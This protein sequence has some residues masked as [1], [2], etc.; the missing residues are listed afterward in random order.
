MPQT[1]EL[2]L[3]GSATVLQSLHLASWSR[4]STF[5]LLLCRARHSLMKHVDRNSKDWRDRLG[6]VL[7]TLLSW[8]GSN[9]GRNISLCAHRLDDSSIPSPG[10]LP[11]LVF[12]VII[13]SL[14]IASSATRSAQPLNRVTAMRQFCR[15]QR[16]WTVRSE[17]A[18]CRPGTG[19]CQRSLAG[20]PRA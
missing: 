8:W 7:A 13:S 2:F 18:P 17:T 10:I 19:W 4:S 5:L 1:S 14:L 16:R 9:S 15:R 20:W 3:P 11:D 6:E 12:A